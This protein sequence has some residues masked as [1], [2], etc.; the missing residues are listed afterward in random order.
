MPVSHKLLEVPVALAP[1]SPPLR[2]LRVKQAV[3]IFNVTDGHIHTFSE[4]LA[5]ICQVV[6][7]RPPRFHLPVAPFRLLAGLAEDVCGLVGLRSPI[8]RATMHNTMPNGVNLSRSGEH[9]LLSAPEC[10]QRPLK[11]Q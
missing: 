1:N 3:E 5:A 2:W 9:S 10:L 11:D 8:V 6:N 7:R 4:I